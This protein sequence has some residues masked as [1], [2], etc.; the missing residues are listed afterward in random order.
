MALLVQNLPANAEDTK[1]AH[2]I[3]GWEDTVG[4][5]MATLSSILAWKIPWA[6]EPDAL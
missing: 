6:E 2:L 1:Y 5:A 3:L 4:K